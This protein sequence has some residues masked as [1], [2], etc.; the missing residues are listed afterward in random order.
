MSQVNQRSSWTNWLMLITALILISASFFVKNLLTAKPQLER[1]AKLEAQNSLSHGRIDV[2]R[3]D[4]QVEAANGK[5]SIYNLD[6]IEVNSESEATLRFENAFIVHLFPD[7]LVTIEKEKSSKDSDKDSPVLMIVKKGEFKIENFGRNQ[8]LIISKDGERIF[9][10]D[11]ST[12]IKPLVVDLKS[13]QSTPEF[14]SPEIPISE[15]PTQ[16]QQTKIGLRPVE[17]Q[18]LQ[19]V[20][21]Q[22]PA[23]FRC[24]TQL[25]LK[26]PNVKGQFTFE[27]EVT[28]AGKTSRVQIVQ[29]PFGDDDFKNCLLEVFRRQEFR[30]FQ[31]KNVTLVVPIA[32]E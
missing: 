10:E 17:Q 9:A 30:S 7:T 14:T 4:S 1:L 21:G 26:S 16:S 31:G 20:A 24:Y 5:V 32:F 27:V 28:P 15:K 25:L 12:E 23:F 11:F 13:S 6:S 29:G 2:I 19:T 22:R 8:S 18:V 3:A